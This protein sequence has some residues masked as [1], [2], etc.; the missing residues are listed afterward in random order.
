MMSA[1]AAEECHIRRDPTEQDSVAQRL[2]RATS[3]RKTIRLVN[4]L[5]AIGI[6]EWAGRRGWRPS[7]WVTAGEVD[8][9]GTWPAA[10]TSG[11][12]AVGAC[13]A[14]RA[15]RVVPITLRVGRTANDG[16]GGCRAT[17]FPCRRRNGPRRSRS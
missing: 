15:P 7:S 14:G 8:N 17:I 2:S 3:A 13:A 1:V 10:Y 16:R 11:G 6:E 12:S 4:A 9:G 5:Q